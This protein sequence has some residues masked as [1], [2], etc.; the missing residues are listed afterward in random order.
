MKEQ[1]FGEFWLEGALEGAILR[2]QNYLIA[3]Q[4]CVL[5]VPDSLLEYGLLSKS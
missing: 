1:L 4:S 3:M 5:R 2:R